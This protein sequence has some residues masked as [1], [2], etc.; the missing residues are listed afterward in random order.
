M[1]FDIFILGEQRSQEKQKQ[2]MGNP[3]Q[4]KA[5]PGSESQNSVGQK[6]GARSPISQWII[7]TKIDETLSEFQRIVFW[8]KPFKILKVSKCLYINY[9]S[10]CLYFSRVKVCKL[11]VFESSL[12]NVRR[13]VNFCNHLVFPRQ[14]YEILSQ[15]VSLQVC[16]FWKSSVRLWDHGIR[17][18]LIMKNF[19][20]NQLF[21]QYS[22][23]NESKIFPSHRSVFYPM[24][25]NCGRVDEQTSVV[26][27]SEFFQSTCNKFVLGCEWSS[28][29]SQNVQNFFLKKSRWVFRK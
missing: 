5:E 20:H 19:Y 6:F 23:E 25:A 26:H 17:W 18:K 11:S 16:S 4:N 27:V 28:K 1:E 15:K 21:A 14:V 12:R 3:L 7:I 9:R 22:S 10:H 24:Y 29:I 8:I 2:R 13:R